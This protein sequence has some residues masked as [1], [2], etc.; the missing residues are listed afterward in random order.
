MP[1]NV[2]TPFAG[3]EA[4]ENV[5]ASASGSVPDSVIVDATCSVTD[6]LWLVAVGAS[7]TGVMAITTVAGAESN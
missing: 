3:P 7:L 4:I 5:S 6:T 2:A 1:I